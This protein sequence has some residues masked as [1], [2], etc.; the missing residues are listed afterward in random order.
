MKLIITSNNRGNTHILPASKETLSESPSCI[1][2]TYIA[3]P[4]RLPPIT[5]KP[6]LMLI[7]D[8]LTNLSMHN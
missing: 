7:S 4:H 5:C 1:M 3:P 6:H 8:H 2:I